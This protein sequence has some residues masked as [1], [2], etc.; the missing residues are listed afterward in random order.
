MNELEAAI[1]LGNIDLFSEIL[2][3]R[4]KNLLYMIKEFVQF[5][6]FLYTISEEPYEEIGPHALP[7]ILGKHVKFTR[8]EL[9]LFLEKKGI[10]TRNLFLSMPT[11]CEGF[12][13]LGHKLGQFPNAEYI[14]DNGL[15]IGIHQN[16]KKE[17]LDYVLSAI[18]EFLSKRK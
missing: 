12:R 14:G 17:D 3:K 10:D 9:V 15:H 11:Q 16:L 13:F 6:P 2:N 5:E 18:K 8:N 7:I 1:G 4:R